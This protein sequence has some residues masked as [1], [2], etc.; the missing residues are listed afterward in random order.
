MT[1][2]R[3]IHSRSRLHLSDGL[4]ISKLLRT[5]RERLVAAFRFLIGGPALRKELG[6]RK[7]EK[8]G[9]V[10]PFGASSMPSYRRSWVIGK[11]FDEI[12]WATLPIPPTKVRKLNRLRSVFGSVSSEYRWLGAIFP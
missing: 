2:R 5:A 4:M 11:V 8:C 12:H 10:L 6:S 9:T 1:F 7:G 3:L